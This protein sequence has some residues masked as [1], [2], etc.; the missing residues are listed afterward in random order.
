MSTCWAASGSLGPFPWWSNCP[1]RSTLA[2][3]RASLLTQWAW[4]VSTRTVRPVSAFHT[5]ISRSLEPD[6]SML[7]PVHNT[8]LT[9]LLCPAARNSRSAH[10]LSSQATP[11]QRS[12][13][14]RVV[15]SAAQ[16]V[17]DRGQEQHAPAMQSSC[18][19]VAASQTRTVPS[20]DDDANFRQGAARWTGC[21]AIEVIH[22]VWPR[23]LPEHSEVTASHT[24]TV[25]SLS[26]VARRAASGDQ[27]HA[28]THARCAHPSL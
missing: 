13:C 28:I 12:S 25:P 26:P 24:H 1:V 19:R 15:C 20:L 10:Q 9:V 17:Q 14:C 3:L 8:E 6:T 4:P 22:L 18:A 16:A 5:R 27:E 23:Q 21:Q 11:P 2:E 7:S